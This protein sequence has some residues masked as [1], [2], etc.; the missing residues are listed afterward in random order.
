MWP[1]SNPLQ[2]VI[3]HFCTLETA[4]GSVCVLLPAPHVLVTQGCWKGRKG[5]PNN[6]NVILV[7]PSLG[8]AFHW[9]SFLISYASREQPLHYQPALHTSCSDMAAF[10]WTT[11]ALSPAFSAGCS[12]FSIPD[13]SSAICDPAVL[14][15]CLLSYVVHCTCPYSQTHLAAV[16]PTLIWPS[17]MVFWAYSWSF[18]GKDPKLKPC[19]NQITYL[20]IYLQDAL[21]LLILP[22]GCCCLTSKYLGACGALDGLRDHSFLRVTHRDPAGPWSLLVPPTNSRDPAKSGVRQ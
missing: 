13:A 11:A 22:S 8:S 3:S 17:W 19:F 21:C 9:I 12:R 4:T 10:A 7:P 1:S 16:I 6:C 5:E 18:L 20:D 14:P 2:A 15:P